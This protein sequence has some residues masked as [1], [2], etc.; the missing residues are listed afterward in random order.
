LRALLDA[1]KRLEQAPLPHGTTA[2]LGTHFFA[3][4]SAQERTDVPGDGTFYRVE[5]RRDEGPAVLEHRAVPRESSD[6]WRFCKLELKGAPLPAGPL[7]VYEDGAFKV[8]TR[9][10]PSATTQTL[11]I[12]LGV[13]PDVRV[14]GRT[15]HTDQQEKGLVSQ[16][17]R[18]T[19]KVKLEV[20]SSR[21]EPVALALFDRLPVPADNVKD[22]TVAVVEEKPPM[23]R[24]NK[25]ATGAEVSGA[26]EWRTTMMPGDLF[27]VSYTYAIDL[28]AKAELEGGNRR[29]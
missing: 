9:L 11:D 18:V 26:V 3:V 2:L 20:R 21:R 6:V 28:P 10:D 15:V 12:N 7:A 16:T 19:H 24:T 23:K 1:Q 29:E 4:L 27:T 17:S 8:R 5:V 25:D 14:V 13:D 22:I